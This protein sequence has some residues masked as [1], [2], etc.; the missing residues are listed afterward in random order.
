M[1]HHTSSA[2]NKEFVV[3][4]SMLREVLDDIQIKYSTCLKKCYTNAKYLESYICHRGMNQEGV[5]NAF[6]DVRLPNDVDA[7]F[8]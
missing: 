4:E 5:A 6:V 1:Q 2:P 7:L 8:V 3:E